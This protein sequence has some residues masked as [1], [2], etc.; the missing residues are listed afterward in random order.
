MGIFTAFCGGKC[1]LA[2]C[3]AALALV[4]LRQTRYTMIWT[5]NIAAV[6]EFQSTKRNA[7][8]NWAR[9]AGSDPV[10]TSGFVRNN[11]PHAADLCIG[12]LTTARKPAYLL[13][14]VHSIHRAIPHSSGRNRVRLAVVNVDHTQT[15]KRESSS[16]PLGNIDVK[17]L[18]RAGV[19]IQRTSTNFEAWQDRRKQHC[20]R[21]CKKLSWEQQE[22]VDYA[23]GLDWCTAPQQEGGCGSAS[24]CLLVEDDTVAGRDLLPRVD[25]LLEQLPPCSGS[26]AAI[27]A[28]GS[29][30]E[31]RVAIYSANEAAKRSGW[32]YVKLFYPGDAWNGWECYGSTGKFV[33]H[34]I[35]TLVGIGVVSA[36]GS[37]LLLDCVA[38]SG[39]LAS[40][41]QLH[42]HT[43]DNVSTLRSARSYLRRG[44]QHFAF[45]AL[46]AL[47]AWFVGKQNVPFV[48]SIQDPTTLGG[49]NPYTHEAYLHRPSPRTMYIVESLH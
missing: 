42:I 22:A 45:G 28:T 2:V 35:I 32:L 23:V 36:I 11:D 44:L 1:L 4:I 27:D 19:S 26:S 29:S 12:I 33:L 48:L 8:M 5:P 39:C 31:E 13:Q 46:L 34:D 40:N 21:G 16:G 10:V 17:L 18:Q 38:A 30:E 37:W 41:Q 49:A 3:M 47:S 20:S 7:A 25:E 43:Q 6:K 15:Q 24:R 14:T 9:R